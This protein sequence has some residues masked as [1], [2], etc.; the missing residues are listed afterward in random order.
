M[1]CCSVRVERWIIRLW[2]FSEC[3][4]ER[5]VDFLFVVLGMILVEGRIVLVVGL[6]VGLV[7]DQGVYQIKVCRVVCRWSYVTGG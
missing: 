4:C 6:R 2:S 7:A 5:H 3:G 1:V